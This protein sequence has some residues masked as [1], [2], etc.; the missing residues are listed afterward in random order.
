MRPELPGAARRTA[1]G[2]PH[3]KHT[4]LKVRE[5]NS[6]PLPQNPYSLP[7]ACTEA[8]Y[9][10]ASPGAPTCPGWPM[11]VFS[12]KSH[13]RGTYLDA[14]GAHGWEGKWVGREGGHLSG[15]VLATRDPETARE[16]GRGAPPGGCR[17]A[18]CLPTVTFLSGDA[19]AP[20]PR[21]LRPTRRR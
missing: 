18:L 12:W 2:E 17:R 5:K 4:F 1:A 7:P 10:L 11:S 21:L 16:G 8:N 6:L 13:P 14:I 3:R 9:F 19:R 15:R 20:E